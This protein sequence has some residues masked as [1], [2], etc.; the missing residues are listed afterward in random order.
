MELDYGSGVKSQSVRSSLSNVDDLIH[1]AGPLTED[2][3]LKT[4]QA[5]YYQDEFFV[6]LFIYS[7]LI[8]YKK[9]KKKKKKNNNK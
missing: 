9:K 8:T 2:A 5:R 7:M 1:L 4:L 3:V 6:N